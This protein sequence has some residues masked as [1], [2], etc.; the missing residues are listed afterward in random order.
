[1]IDLNARELV[2]RERILFGWELVPSAGFR[3]LAMVSV[4]ILFVGDSKLDDLSL[5]L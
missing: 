1:M 4:E 2:T 3:Q 5:I